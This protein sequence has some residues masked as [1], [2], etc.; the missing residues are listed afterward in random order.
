M[1]VREE[2]LT[3]KGI[4]VDAVRSWTIPGETPLTITVHRPAVTVQCGDG[5]EVALSP[6][7][8]E[9]LGTRMVEAEDYFDSEDPETL[10]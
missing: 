5:P 4:V 6:S 2:Q 7:Q 8:V 10:E 1:P 3:R 9:A